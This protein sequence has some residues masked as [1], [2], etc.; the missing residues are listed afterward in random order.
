MDK[1]IY[2][3]LF[4]T[5][6]Y[7]VIQKSEELCQTCK[8]ESITPLLLFVSMLIV[9]KDFIKDIFQRSNLDYKS[10]CQKVERK[11]NDI[12]KISKNDY[13]FSDESY[14]IVVSV[15]SNK[16]YNAVTIVEFL[17]ELVEN[18]E[19]SELIENKSLDIP[20]QNEETIMFDP[21]SGEFKDG[22]Q[23]FYDDIA[24]RIDLFNF[25]GYIGEGFK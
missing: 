1:A 21:Y 14:K 13:S 20:D 3:R 18:D 2:E 15:I 9:E 11:L 22:V 5:R 8:Y 23:S 12:S 10:I 7:L 25:S 16:T 19:I 6:A 17:H 24:R 4:T